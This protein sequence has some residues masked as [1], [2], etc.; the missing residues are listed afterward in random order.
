[1]RFPSQDL[2]KIPSNTHY[3][4]VQ[5]NIKLG[6]G[7]TKKIFDER[8]KENK[9]KRK[10]SAIVQGG[11]GHSHSGIAAVKRCMSLIQKEKRLNISAIFIYLNKFQLK[12][13][14]KKSYGYKPTSRTGNSFLRFYL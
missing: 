9:E 12:V 5:A 10:L 8:K 14:L 3:S 13:I 11:I 6:H 7:N 4:P 2:C 1:M